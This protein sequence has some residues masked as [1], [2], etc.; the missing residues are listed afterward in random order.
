M[1]KHSNRISIGCASAFWGDSE[2]AAAQLVNFGNIDFLVFDY[3]SEITMSLL[4]R[5]KQKNG[6][7]GY[8]EDFVKWVIEPLIIEIKAKGIRVVSNA[9]GMN[10]QACREA[11]E[12]I[13][14]ELGLTLKIA[15]V[16]GDDLLS[17]KESLQVAN[18]SHLEA[19]TLPENLLSLNAYLGAKPIANALDAGADIV[20]TGRCVDSALALGPLIHSF[21]WSLNDYERLSMGSLAGHIIECGTQCTGGNFTDWDT[22]R[23]FDNMGFP[24]VECESSGSFVI[25]K[26]PETGGKVTPL[27]VAEQILYEI[28]D[29]RCYF[30]PDVTCDWTEV[31]LKQVGED[32]VEVQGAKGYPPTSDYKVSAT[33][34]EEFR[35]QA[36]FMIC[37]QDAKLKARTVAKALFLRTRRLFLE[38]GF[39]DYTETLVETIGAEDTYG[40]HA[41]DYDTREVAVRISGKH[42]RKVALELFSREIAQLATATV[43]GIAGFQ[44]GRPR[45][46]PVI[47]LHTCLIPKQSINVEYNI[48]GETRVV[49]L[50]T[51]GGFVPTML[52]KE[53]HMP[54]L[55]LAMSSSLTKVPLVKLAVARSGDKGDDVNI[56]VIARDSSYLPFI[57]VA[58]TEQAV[59]EFFSHVLQ[60]NVRR[61]ELPGISALNFLLTK[62][63]DGG[64]LTTLRADAQGKSFAQ[65]LLEFKV[66]VP[67]KLATKLS[68]TTGQLVLRQ[69]D[70]FIV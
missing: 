41:S 58:L 66:T 16:L 69:A 53:K 50:P 10:P 19:D 67:K 8:T 24:I 20:I 54:I 42:K 43:P 29:P 38:R 11:I 23:G 45:V 34:P 36:M 56:G 64:G 17:Q 31:S 4:A 57:R 61:W 7:L 5:E 37:G 65:M 3:L 48:N 1:D 59:A 68:H 9:G 13:A 6:K 39:G 47:K 40:P 35:S 27:T 2:A 62:T 70:K 63:L 32:R 28:G 44:A 49:E 60:G 55:H 52:P 22:V 46:S 14:K 21:Q 18:L 15:I 33:T 12:A 30:L 51:A 25:T 26:P